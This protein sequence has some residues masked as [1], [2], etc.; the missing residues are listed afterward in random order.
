MRIAFPSVFI[1]SL[2]A[3]VACGS[4]SKSAEPS[5][6]PTDTDDTPTDTDTTD[7]A[8][9]NDSAEPGDSA[10]TSD[11]ADTGETIDHCTEVDAF[12]PEFSSVLAT[13]TAQDNATPWPTGGLVATGSSSIRRWEGLAREYSDHTVIQ[14]GFGGAQLGEVALSVN[15]L[16]LRHAPAGIVVFAGTND[17]SHGVSADVVAERLRCFVQKV[18]AE[19]TSPIFFIGVTP[20]PAR[21]E[22]WAESE[23][24]N[25]LAEAFAETD[26]A[27]HYIDV[28]TAFLATGSP[29]DRSLFVADGL[30]LSASGYALWDSVLHPVVDSALSSTAPSPS[31]TLAPGTRVLVDFGASDSTNGEPTPSP[32][33]LGQHWNNWHPRAGGEAIWPGERLPGLLTDDG[34][35]TDL[36]LVVTGGFLNNGREHGGLLWPSQ[37]HLGTLA[38]GTATEEFFYTLPDDQTGGLQLRGLSPAQTHT[39]RLFGSRA[40]GETRTTRYTVTGSTESSQVLQTTGPGAGTDNGNDQS[41]VTF[42]GVVP[43]AHGHVHLDVSIEAGA[44]GYL[45]LLELTVE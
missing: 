6:V 3:L 22:G 37:D 4:P 11:S 34:T 35:A 27:L 25:A 38:V 24:F 42:S 7:S 19:S 28:P 31:S 8:D 5:T 20:T 33:Y 39:L 44:Y 41:V 17:L 29:P 14:R 45:N 30:H 18:R 21:W 12:G 43:D 40:D 15:D 26:P 13:W 9:S 32:D 1:G 10:D 36:E 23:R 2:A 16:V